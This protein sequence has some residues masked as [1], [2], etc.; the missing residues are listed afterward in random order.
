MSAYENY[1]AVSE[2]YDRTR[3]PGRV[4]DHPGLSG[5]RRTLARFASSARRRMRD[6]QLLRCAA[7]VRRRNRRGGPKPVDAR[8]G[9]DKAR[10]QA[11]M[12]G[13]PARGRHRRAAV[14]GRLL[15]RGDGEPGASTIFRI[16]RTTA[17]RCCAGC[18]ASSRGCCAPAVW[19]SS[20]PAPTSSSDAAGG[21]RRSFRKRSRRFAGGSRTRRC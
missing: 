21:T 3:I 1:T 6:G 9:T 8:C 4:G 13:R 12:P 18:S 17:G 14:R 16:H 11:G 15:R 19:R 10:R 2:D 20:T 7:S 5:V